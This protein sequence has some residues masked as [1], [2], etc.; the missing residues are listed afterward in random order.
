[1]SLTDTQCRTAKAKVNRYKLFDYEGLYLEIMPSGA[2]S[3]RLKYRL[4]EKEK[5]ISLGTYPDVSLAGAREKCKTFRLTYI[6]GKPI[7]TC[8]KR[9]QYETHER[10]FPSAVFGFL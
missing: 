1:M 6:V 2:K 3:W 10:D 9:I 8:F 5:R 7:R 4:H